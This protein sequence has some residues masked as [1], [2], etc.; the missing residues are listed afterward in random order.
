MS[1]SDSFKQAMEK[2]GD[3]IKDISQL[4]VRTYG[5][6]LTSNV[7]AGSPVDWDKMLED[8]KTT[9][10]ISLKLSTDIMIDGD[11]NHFIADDATEKHQKAH[12]AALAAGKETRAGIYE[13]IKGIVENL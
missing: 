7:T 6:D 5:G 8:A 12:D 2:I 4:N 1:Y 9:G 11:C 10:A 13:L 3:F